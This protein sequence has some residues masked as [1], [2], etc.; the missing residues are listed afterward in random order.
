MTVALVGVVMGRVLGDRRLGWLAA[1]FLA[2][3]YWHLHFSRYAIRAILA[4]MWATG[5]IGAWW[6]ATEALVRRAGHGPRRAG[7]AER[8]ESSE[9]AHVPRLTVLTAK[10][11]TDT[12]GKLPRWARWSVLCGVCLAAAVYSHPSG[13]LL[14]LVLL[15]HAAHRVL[16]AWRGA[17]GRSGDVGIQLSARSQLR[18]LAVAGGTALVLFVPLGL[19]FLRHP[20]QFSGHASDVS[21][22][23]VALRD[24][25]GSLWRA[26]LAN[27]WAILGMFAASGDPSTF[28]NLPGLPV[29]DP[30]TAL[31]AA[32]GA[33]VLLG[34]LLGRG[35]EGRADKAALLIAWLGV[36]LV[37]TLLSDRPPNYSRAIAALPAIA[38]L[39]ALGLGWVVPR[40]RAR[41]PMRLSGAGRRASEASSASNAWFAPAVPFVVLILWSGAWTAWH[42]FVTFENTEHVYYSYD[43]EKLDA[44]TALR[45]MTRGEAAEL[46]EEMGGILYTPGND[47][48]EATVFLHPLW[49][50]HA[51]LDYLNRFVIPGASGEGDSVASTP[52]LFRMLDPRDTLVLPAN[53]DRGVIVAAPTKE[54]EREGIIESAESM[55]LGGAV[56]RA[57]DDVAEDAPD[58]PSEAQPSGIR[59]V[60]FDA[61]GQPMLTTLFVLASAW[62]DLEPPTDAPLE[63]AIW[64]KARFGGA[65]DLIG[66]TAGTARAGEV[67]PITIV[68]RALEPLGRNLTV[69]V[70]LRSPDGESWGQDD[71]EPGHASY[72]TSDWQSGDVIVDRYRP[73]L[74]S[75]SSGE[76]AFCIGWYDRESGERLGA[77]DDRDEFCPRAIPIRSSE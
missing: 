36:G 27:A 61:H 77:G 44:L 49:A 50:R 17:Y 8:T 43:V 9:H 33:G 52:L 67:L 18:A 7:S 34:A 20:E 10:L 45:S 70:H 71:R 76:V 40:L 63:P 75:D 48:Q 1:A 30:L 24:H 47:G 29:Y 16:A 26:L 4:P 21:L 51:T 38:L 25:G 35:G 32:I 68:W 31:A 19:F 56:E 3:T 42:Y 23:A 58:A 39:P 11:F 53:A 15:A 28:H 62:G 6:L 54:D 74:S 5:A 12:M 69:F 59:D 55:L 65:I 13:R 60:I 22:A 14:P 72:R 73:V 66:Y 46:A 57:V 64:T 41:L 37:P 2:M